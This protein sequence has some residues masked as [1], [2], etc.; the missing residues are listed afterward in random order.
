MVENGS[1]WD[2]Q[3]SFA[4]DHPRKWKFG[5]PSIAEVLARPADYA[6]QE[7]QKFRGRVTNPGYTLLKEQVEEVLATLTDR[8][9][10]VIRLRFGLDG[11]H[12]RTQAQVGQEIGRSRWT[13]SRIE[14]RAL[15]KLRHPSTVQPLKDYLS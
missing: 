12:T 14:R 10:K 13:A 3:E 15:K 4:K 9:N 7:E 11:G 8:E 6:E 2:F 1:H 5:R